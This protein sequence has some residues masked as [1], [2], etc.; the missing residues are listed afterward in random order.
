VGEAS[1]SS[2]TE[3]ENS[4]SLPRVSNQGGQST[5]RSVLQVRTTSPSSFSTE[6]SPS[7]VALPLRGWRSVP[8]NST[9][10][11]ICRLTVP[12]VN[13]VPCLLMRHVPGARS[14]RDRTPGCSDV[15]IDC[16][17]SPGY[18]N[19]PLRAACVTRVNKAPFCRTALLML[20][21]VATAARVS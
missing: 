15:A 19:R 17:G 8:P 11:V 9:D 7:S 16:G 3:F 18:A 4:T 14:G 5:E 10:P 1:L 12:P 6:Y 20:T 21:S 2:P 13:P